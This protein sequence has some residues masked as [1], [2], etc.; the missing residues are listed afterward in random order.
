MIHVTIVNLEGEEFGKAQF[1][2]AAELET[3]Q[4][5]ILASSMSGL[6]YR[7]DEKEIGQ[8]EVCDCL[9]ERWEAEDIQVE[10]R[11]C[12]SDDCAREAEDDLR[13]ARLEGQR[14]LEMCGTDVDSWF[15]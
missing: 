3:A 4:D 10:G 5:K 13:I 1:D 11:D 15:R 9:F 7:W 14:E 12:C 6:E 2:S 8:C